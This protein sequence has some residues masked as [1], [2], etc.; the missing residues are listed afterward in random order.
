[1]A[2]KLLAALVEAAAQG[3]GL[4][5]TE[6]QDLFSRHHSQDRLDAARNEVRKL[7]RRRGH[8]L[9]EV[10]EKTGGKPCTTDR[11]VPL[12]VSENR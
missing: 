1:V 6:Q 9:I 7:L 2:D 10:L 11:I 3:K 8:D 5:R 4:T 12:A